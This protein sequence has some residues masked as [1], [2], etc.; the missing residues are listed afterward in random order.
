MTMLS[1]DTAGDTFAFVFFTHR[2]GIFCLALQETR[3]FV[4]HRRG[5]LLSR[6]ARA[7]AHR[8]CIL[9]SQDFRLQF[10]RSISREN[11][12]EKSGLHHMPWLEDVCLKGERFKGSRLKGLRLKIFV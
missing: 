1:G 6:F 2:S 12:S 4:T 7:F 11:I 3:A 5:N 10:D 9:C 8:L